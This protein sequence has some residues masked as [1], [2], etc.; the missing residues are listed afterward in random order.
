M[1]EADFIPEPWGAFLRELDEIATE[2]V[3]FHCIGGFVVTKK[4]GFQRETSDVDVL[5][6]SPNTQQQDFLQKG[7]LNSPLHLKHHVYL[8]VVT[9]VDA[10]PED[11]ETRLTEMYP[12]QLKRIRLLALEAHDLA[13]TKLGRNNERDRAD[14]IFLAR[15]G[16]LAAEKLKQRYKIEMR[17]YIA[18]AE[19]RRD[20]VIDLWTEMISESLN[21]STNGNAAIAEPDVGGQ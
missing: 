6:I 14:V 17:P 18:D 16:F 20:P 12:G 5:S 21:G 9:V 7:A 3:D 1:S 11:Y 2:P 8:D 4:Y 15:Q 19:H 13:L 10:Y